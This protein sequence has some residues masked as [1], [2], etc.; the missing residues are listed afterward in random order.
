MN[1]LKNVATLKIDTETCVGCGLCITVCPHGVF[2]LADN[3]AHIINLDACM[4]CGACAKNCP[5]DALTINCGISSGLRNG[6]C[7]KGGGYA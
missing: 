2:A 5:A 1:Y 4:E 6:S 7:D 3:K